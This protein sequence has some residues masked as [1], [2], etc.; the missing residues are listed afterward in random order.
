MVL[1]DCTVLHCTA[2]YCTA[3]VRYLKVL[4][5]EGEVLY[6]T[7]RLY[8]TVYSTARY[9][10]ALRGTVLYCGVL[11]RTVLYSTVLHCLYYTHTVLYVMKRDLS[12]EEHSANPPGSPICPDGGNALS[13]GACD[14]VHG[15]RVGPS[16]DMELGPDFIIEVK[17]ESE[18]IDDYS[19]LVKGETHLVKSTKFK[20]SFLQ[21][22][23]D[24]LSN[25]HVKQEARD[26]PPREN[27]KA[28]PLLEGKQRKLVSCSKC[29]QLFDVEV[30]NP[31]MTRNTCQETDKFSSVSSNRIC[32][33]C[34]E[35]LKS[36]Q[37]SER[38][39]EYTI[40]NG[41][42]NQY[43]KA[44][45]CSF[46]SKAFAFISQLKIHQIIHTGEKLYNCSICMKA[47]GSSSHLNIHQR[48]HTGEKPYKCSIC[49]K[50]FRSSSHLCEHQRTHTD[51]KP[52]KCSICLRVFARSSYL[53]LHQRT[54]TGEKPYK[55]N[56]CP[57]AFSQSS[58]LKRHQRMH[59]NTNGDC[60]KPEKTHVC[61]FCMKAF[62]S[63][64]HL[65]EHQ[66]THTGEKPFQCSL[67][68]KAFA[69][70]SYLD[71]HQRTHT[72]E[73]PYKCSVCS[74]VFAHS[75]TLHNHQKLH[76]GVKKKMS[77]KIEIKNELDRTGIDK[78]GSFDWLRRGQINQDG[79]RVIINARDQGQIRSSKMNI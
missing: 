65:D 68:M 70:S 1:F 5:C 10:T 79:E 56:L 78:K 17:V 22:S 30:F 54:H 36:I 46:C 2:L 60:E 28:A 3:S 37:G 48:I 6:C 73:K 43:K 72:G 14:G 55:C 52:F 49:N 61:S 74:K 69:R 76:T 57:K 19:S 66:R 12:G 18:F 75:S 8:C 9:C 45:K 71:V 32:K 34:T 64:S 26:S 59:A 47:F 62:G 41:D 67:C 42:N 50:A 15:S 11:Y 16:E 44:H 29:F 7:A 53:I 21:T 63:S 31:L 13:P 27:S 40:A 58:H 4:Y 51:E 25:E 20:S 38:P 77:K 39:H 24:A 23:Q 35:T 33:S